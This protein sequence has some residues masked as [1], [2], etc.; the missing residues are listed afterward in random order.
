MRVRSHKTMKVKLTTSVIIP[1]I[2]K[3]LTRII[4]EKI[5]LGGIYNSGHDK[6]EKASSCCTHH[7]ELRERQAK[8]AAQWLWKCSED[9]SALRR[10]SGAL[11]HRF[12][13]YEGLSMLQEI[14]LFNTAVVYN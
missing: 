5:I 10:S 12:Y 11:L 14:A 1:F 13:R 7:Q 6:G 2:E 8:R 3:G 9:D 4:F